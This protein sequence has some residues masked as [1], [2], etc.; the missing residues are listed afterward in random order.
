VGD[1]MTVGERRRLG[2]SMRGYR[3]L[4]LAFVGMVLLLTLASRDAVWAGPVQ[5]PLRQT[6]PTRTPTPGPRPTNTPHYTATPTAT[7]APGVERVILQQGVNEYIGTSDTFLDFSQQSDNHGSAS[8]LDIH[9]DGTQVTLLRFDL[10]EVPT[11]VTILRAD[12]QLFAVGRTASGSTTA[13]VYRVLRHWEENEANWAD[14]TTEGTWFFPGCGGLGTDRAVIADGTEALGGINY[15]YS[16]EVTASV[17]AWLLDQEPNHGLLLLSS[18]GD[19]VGYSFASSGHQVPAYRPALVITYVQ[20]GGTPTMTPTEGATLTPSPTTTPFYQAFQQGISPI[21]YDGVSDTYI[22]NW[23]PRANHGTEWRLNLRSGDVEAGLI[24]F[25]LSILPP[26]CHVDRAELSVYVESRTNVANLPVTV[27]R[28]LRPWVDTEASWERAAAGDDWGTAGCNSTVSDRL[29]TSDDAQELGSKGTSE[30]WYD[31]DV[32]GMTRYWVEH[33]DENHGLILKAG[34][35]TSVEYRLVSSDRVTDSVWRPRLAVYYHIILPTP[36]HTAT[37]QVTATPT[38]GPTM[39]PGGIDGVVWDD[40]NGD[41]RRGEE[42]P[43]VPGVEVVL[44]SG[45]GVPLAQRFTDLQGYYAFTNLAPALYRV[46]AV[47]PTSYEPTTPDEV[48]AWP[49]PGV[50]LPIDFG[51]RRVGGHAVVVLPM[52]L[53]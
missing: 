7:L 28:V 37:P 14:A 18:G 3:W 4:L 36:T 24:R 13:S 51:V 23:D 2:R 47:C 16:F 35:A 10:S 26:G 33:P 49:G 46:Q 50:I 15:R 25:D 30:W 45:D 48:W 42:E 31:F 53:K 44:K 40:L 34:A 12:L 11:D 27:H 20:G 29:S 5:S 6:I 19:D 39:V 38:Q 43:P 8:Q 32:T 52:V 1:W 41:S 17:I 21:G 9:S 22:D